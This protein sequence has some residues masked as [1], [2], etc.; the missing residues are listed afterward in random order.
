MVAR[1]ETEP[2]FRRRTP[3]PLFSQSGYKVAE[4]DGGS[5]WF[6]LAPDGDRFIMLKSGTVEQTSDEPF[7]GFIFVE[8]W[9]EELKERV[10]VNCLPFWASPTMVARPGRATT[11]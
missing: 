3:E 4:A 5:R 6:D 8:N 9:F 2:T 11:R 7:N 1:V 10:T